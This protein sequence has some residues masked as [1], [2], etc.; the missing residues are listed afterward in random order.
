[1]SELGLNLAS[2]AQQ[3]LPKRP[4]SDKG[5]NLETDGS[6]SGDGNNL[7]TDGPAS[8][9]GNN[10]ETN[11]S[12]SGDG[13]NLATDGP[14]SPAEKWKN[15]SETYLLPLTTY[16]SVLFNLVSAPLRLLGKDNPIAHTLQNA[17]LAFTKLHQIGYAASGFGTAF[18]KKNLF[19]VLSFTAEAL[20]AALKLRKIYLF[21]GLASALD[22]TPSCVLKYCPDKFDSWSESFTKTLDAIKKTMQEFIKKPKILLERDS[23]DRQWALFGAAFCVLGNILGFS[24]SES[25]G[26]AIR[27]IGA[28]LN[29]FGL[30]FKRGFP[31]ARQSG[32][33]YFGGSMLDLGAN[34]LAKFGEKQGQAEKFGK[35]RDMLHELALAS[36][37]IGQKIFLHFLN[38]DKSQN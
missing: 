36:D 18:C 33:F 15:F 1:M 27:D 34:L 7:A 37:R 11:G 12:N 17:S 14:A 3:L 4:A 16:S 19:Y 38:Q 24:I 30:F 9:K 21:K 23:F 26:G 20:V 28:I 10:L 29:D 13:N 8:N 35:I 2:T 6:N 32:K 31:L 22:I 25:L 5:N